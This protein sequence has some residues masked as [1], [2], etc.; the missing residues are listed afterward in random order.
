[1]DHA[2]VRGEQREPVAQANPHTGITRALHRESL[3]VLL[4]LALHEGRGLRAAA[5]HLVEGPLFGIELPQERNEHGDPQ[6]NVQ[7]RLLDPI[8]VRLEH[9]TEGTER[10]GRARLPKCRQGEWVGAVH[11]HAIF[12]LVGSHIREQPSRSRWLNIYIPIPCT[13]SAY[14]TKA[15]IL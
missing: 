4:P 8:P 7:E 15:D 14:F 2:A 3:Q 13:M 9:L 12:A 1:M 5:L 10:G 11:R 6:G